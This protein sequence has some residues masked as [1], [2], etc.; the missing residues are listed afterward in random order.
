MFSRFLIEISLPGPL[1]EAT[2]SEFQRRILRDFFTGLPCGR[3]RLR[4]AAA[5]Q[6]A[7]RGPPR[8]RRE[9]RAAAAPLPSPGGSEQTPVCLLMALWVQTWRF[10]SRVH[11]VIR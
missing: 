8:A 5:S 7:V 10:I 11:R 2:V 1:L 9:P 4:H 6:R 3:G